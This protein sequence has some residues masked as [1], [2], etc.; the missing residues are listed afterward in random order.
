[1]KTKLTATV[2]LMLLLAP[3]AFGQS[4]TTPR[5][6]APDPQDSARAPQ[7]TPTPTPRGPEYVEEKGFKT[8]IL[9]IKYRDPVSIHR[10]VTSLGSGFR[11]AVISSNSDFKTLTIRD[12]PENI[13]VIEE[14]VK[15]LDT[16]VAARPDIEFHVHVIIA[17]N[18]PTST[19][20]LPA[21]LADVVR[22]LQATLKYKSYGVMASS[23]HRAAEGGQGLSNNGV[24]ESKLFNVSTPGG[25]PIFYQYMLSP[26]TVRDGAGS[27]TIDI[28]RFSFGMRIPLNV[29]GATSP[30]QYENV[31]FNTPVAIRENEKVVVGTTTMGDKGLIVVVTAKVLK[32]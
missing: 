22:Q 24:A 1:M 2:I 3:A 20:E 10:V 25:N 6:A 15:R 5:A 21:E 31:G 17:S 13:A 18:T 16:P 19:E 28:G 14:A 23:V 4:A 12:F 8:K 30:I 26:L 11:G 9:E 27:A 7:A 32:K 29:G